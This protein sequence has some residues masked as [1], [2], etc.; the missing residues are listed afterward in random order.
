MR[1]RAVRLRVDIGAAREVKPV[2]TIEERVRL[3]VG[4]TVGR[5]H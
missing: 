2:E 3:V 4:P 1:S 5:Q